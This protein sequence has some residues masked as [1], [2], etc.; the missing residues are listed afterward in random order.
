MLR[1]VICQ[2]IDGFQN[3]IHFPKHFSKPS[4]RDTSLL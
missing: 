3:I 1:H 2:P 4:M